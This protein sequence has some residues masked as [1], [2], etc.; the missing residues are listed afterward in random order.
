M[1]ARAVSIDGKGKGSSMIDL[2]GRGQRQNEAD[3]AEFLQKLAADDAPRL[4][5]IGLELGEQHDTD[6]VAYG[7]AFRDHVELVSCEGDYHVRTSSAEDALRHFQGGE[8]VTAH[9]VWLPA[10]TAGEP[11][12]A[13]EVATSE[14]GRLA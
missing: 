6:I 9:L 13:S 14:A 8:G 1:T 2:S 11:Q 12:D 3:F 4:F 7:M 10:S 5:A